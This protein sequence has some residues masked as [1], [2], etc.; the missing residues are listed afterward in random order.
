MMGRREIGEMMKQLPKTSNS[1][2]VRTDFG[3]QRAWEAICAEIERPS[4]EGF[5]AQVEFIEDRAFDGATLGQL[6]AAVPA[7]YP[8]TFMVVVDRDTVVGREHPLLVVN[9]YD[10]LGSEVGAAFRCVPSA[11]QGIENNLSI[12]NMDFE[13]FAGAVDGDGV[14]RSFQ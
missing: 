3:E 14:F 13:E 6:L 9:L 8:H 5:L 1:P 4:D 12:A 7:E 11:I 2:V 10:G